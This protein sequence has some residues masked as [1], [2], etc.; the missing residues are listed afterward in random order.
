MASDI[1]TK[2]GN[3][4]HHRCQLR[5]LANS[6]GHPRKVSA[7]SRGE[8]SPEHSYLPFRSENELHVW[9]LELAHGG[10]AAPPPRMA[11][12][13]PSAAARGGN[14]AASDSTLFHGTTDCRC[15]LRLI[16]SLQPRRLETKH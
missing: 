10:S 16:T 14:S 4:S 9:L 3:A 7:W 13:N 5:L 15:R 6:S 8:R 2:F 12:H 11:Q 1:S